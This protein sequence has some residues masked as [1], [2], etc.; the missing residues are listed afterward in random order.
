[1]S[2][3]SKIRSN[4]AIEDCTSIDTWSMEPIGKNNRLCKVVKATMVP[5]LG[6]PWT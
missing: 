4:R 1:M 5:G 6:T 2:R 3:Y